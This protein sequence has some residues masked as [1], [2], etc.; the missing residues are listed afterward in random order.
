[1]SDFFKGLSFLIKWLLILA[2]IG[3]GIYIVVVGVCFLWEFFMRAILPILVFAI[4]IIAGIA[5]IIWIIK[6]I[7]RK[8]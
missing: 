1:M 3:L 8:V 4:P 2:G 7:G 6:I 5:L